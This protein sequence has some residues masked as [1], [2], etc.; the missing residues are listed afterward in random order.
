MI[1]FYLNLE[2]D[3]QQEEFLQGRVQGN[4]SSSMDTGLAWVPSWGK[5]RTRSAQTASWWPC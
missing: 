4:P 1:E 3:R 2:K 5:S